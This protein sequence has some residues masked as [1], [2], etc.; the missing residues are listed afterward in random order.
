MLQSNNRFSKGYK[1][2]Q[3]KWRTKKKDSNK[4][5]KNKYNKNKFIIFLIKEYKAKPNKFRSV[6]P[7]FRN[8]QPNK[9]ETY[10]W[11]NN[12]QNL[13]LHYKSLTLH[14]LV[15]KF[16]LKHGLYNNKFYLRFNHNSLVIK[17]TSLGVFRGHKAKKR[18][19][20]YT[21]KLTSQ[22]NL[23]NLANFILN[24]NKLSYV[25]LKFY[26]R[27]MPKKLVEQESTLVFKKYKKERFFWESLQLVNAVFKGYASASILG[28]L[29]YAH[30]RR[31][32][33]RTAF[34]AYLKRLLDWHFKN[35]YRSRIQGVRVEV[36]GRFNAKSR[37]KKRIVSAGRVR[38]HEK[39]SNVDY[40]FTEAFTKFGSLGIKVWVC[41]KSY[42][43]AINT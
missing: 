30:T 4:F 39:S 35:S 31:N 15:K 14:M 9:V 26:H 33:K 13:H 38:M 17:A 36:K 10:S 27:Y 41:P 19:K 1:P 42:K 11:H 2:P 28:G 21:K 40:A 23:T 6:V 25:K 32:P 18:S 43:N 34:V 24:A 12:W 8:Y 20:L 16:F 29:I 5:Y 7:I 37:A 22:N 3:I